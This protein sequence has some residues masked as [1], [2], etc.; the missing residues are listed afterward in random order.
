M[1][2]A[3]EISPAG[4]T[5][6]AP[7]LLITAREAY[8]V[9]EAL[10]LGAQRR[11]SMSFR[12]FDLRTRL[13]S[14]AGLA[15]GNTW[16]DLLAD[17]LRRG[18][19]LRLVIADFDPIGAAELHRSTWR[20]MRQCAGLREIAGKVGT[21]ALEVIAARHPARIGAVPSGLFWPVAAWRLRKAARMLNDLTPDERRRFLSEAPRLRPNLKVEEGAE[22]RVRADF[23]HRFRMTPVTHHQKLAVIDGRR[24]YVGGLDLDE[25]RWDTPT[26][27]QPARETWHDVQMVF[28][29]PELVAQAERHL[30]GFLEQSAGEGPAPEGRG[31]AAPAGGSRFLTTI[32]EPARFAPFRFSPRTRSSGIFDAHLART[33]EARRL[34][35]LETQYF[36]DRRLA[37]ALARRGRE[38]PGLHL[39]MVLPAAPEEVA[40]S[41]GGTDARYG[42]FLQSR[43][44]RA[45]RKAFGDRFI[46]LSP[47][48]RRRPGRPE[49]E[50]GDEAV[51]AP[52]GSD[53]PAHGRS[54]L[55]GAPVI[56]VHAK[57]SVF[58]DRAAIISSAN[59]NG[60]SLRWDT[61]AGVEMSDP[62]TVAMI[63][64]RVLDH[65]YPGLAE[66]RRA[67]MLD[68]ARAFGAWVAAARRDAARPPE[69]REGYLLPYDMRPGRR[70]GM[71]VFGVPEEM[72]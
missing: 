4:M 28:D 34:I 47:A 69:A 18:V 67:E 22:G 15:I 16:A 43:C 56:Y 45:V 31:T 17:A 36:R 59:L 29:E 35:F 19:S 66:G 10:V 26:H 8:P 39:V 71:A 30:E 44:L 65:W 70:F 5:D 55:L 23:A 1:S 20:T 51:G 40:F 46:A 72:V 61:E 60:R 27:D 54:V 37:R 11:V 50:A 68:P 41:S 3:G 64:G 25:R 13:H 48:Q 63:R 33:G 58:D 62:A 42:E 49:E 24:L 53:D 21:G 14:A 57:L 38:E 32:S 52:D 2:G 7:H 9:F 6:G 12:V